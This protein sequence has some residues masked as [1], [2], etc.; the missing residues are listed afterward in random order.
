MDLINNVLWAIATVFIIISGIYFTFK[1]NF[2]QFKISKMMKY[3]FEKEKHKGISTIDSLMLVLAGRIGVGS[4]AGVALAI[5]YGGVGSIFWMWISAIILAPNC[6]AETVLGIMYKKKDEL[7]IYKGGPSYYIGEGLKNKNLAFTYALIILFSYIVGF[8]G[9]QAN[10]ITVSLS[11][12][13]HIDKYIIGIIIC[14]LTSLVIFGGIKRISSITS[15]LVPIMTVFYVV[16]SLTILIL[17]FYL[18]PNIFFS[19]ITNAFNISSFTAS[20]IPMVIIGIQ[21]SIFSNEAGL[22]TGSI[23]SS[24][25]ESNNY[26]KDGY[27]QTFGIYITTLLLGTITA[28]VILTT[29]YSSIN[30]TNING[31]EIT[32]YAYFFHL[33][34]LGNYFVFISIFLFSFSTILT[35]YYYGESAL[36]YLIK[37]NKTSLTI[38]KICTLI[39]VFFGSI[40]SSLFVWKIVD[41]FVAILAIINIYALLKL[42]DEF[43]YL[44]K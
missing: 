24:T 31:I 42:K 2:M 32:Q 38:L 3:L 40:L 18:I 20:F 43:R 23:A 35:G 1:F 6:F 34:E 25:V 12:I 21:R 7:N 4:I 33:N 39:S 10:T 26:I 37:T 41:I 15:K 5:Y 29:D 11:E 27:I 17:N 36:K 28:L 13:I 16:V 19:I 14:I 8:I 9:I 22:G 30:F 44:K